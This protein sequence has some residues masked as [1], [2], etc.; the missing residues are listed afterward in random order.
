M[1]TIQA[2]W[3]LGRLTTWQ[4]TR[5]LALIIIY[6][7]SLAIVTFTRA[8]SE[9]STFQHPLHVPAIIFTPF[10]R[11][12]FRW[13]HQTT[14]SHGWRL[15]P[16]H[17]CPSSRW[18]RCHQRRPS[19]RLRRHGPFTQA[20]KRDFFLC[21][22]CHRWT[23]RSSLILDD[24]NRSASSLNSALD[25]AVRAALA[26]GRPRTP[27]NI[28][29]NIIPVVIVTRQNIHVISIDTQLGGDLRIQARK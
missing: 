5:I 14:E 20:L 8:P 11:F 15:A 27:L 29:T 4:D 16:W 12:H 13:R 22:W 25:D 21:V 7:L 23:C 17:K 9:P 2:I 24:R 10:F 3:R 1:T 6:Q 18:L 26:R 28:I 19:R